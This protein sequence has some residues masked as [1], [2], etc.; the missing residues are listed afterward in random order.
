MRQELREEFK[1]FK[2]TVPTTQITHIYNIVVGPN[3]Y[4][5]LVSRYG[6]DNAI[7]ILASNTTADIA[8]MLYFE[9]TQPSRYPIACKDTNHF[10]YINDKYEIIDDQGGS[11][12]GEVVSE[13]VKNAMILAANEIIL[14]SKTDYNLMDVQNK[15]TR[16]N[17]SNLIQDLARMSFNHG[18]QFFET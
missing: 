1:N 13:N 3:I 12:V 15:L 17:N 2:E 9:D 4:N 16:K 10:R 7:S 8:K 6:R 18:H 14:D 11:K 5:Q